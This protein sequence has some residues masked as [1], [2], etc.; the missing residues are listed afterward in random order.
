MAPGLL[1]IIGNNKIYF[2]GV[3]GF[4]TF[5]HPALKSVVAK[6]C[7]CY[8]NEAKNHLYSGF[9]LKTTPTNIFLTGPI[10]A[11]SQTL[12]PTVRISRP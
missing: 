6:L 8:K 10:L 1:C 2:L 9:L 3:F 4:L 11:R 12:E 5:K 7:K